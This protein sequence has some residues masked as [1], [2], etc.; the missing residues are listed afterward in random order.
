MRELCV[1]EGLSRAVGRS[2]RSEV[3]HG[4]AKKLSDFLRTRAASSVTPTYGLVVLAEL[5]AETA[6]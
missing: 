5:E 6:P 1:P 2:E 3:R 4:A